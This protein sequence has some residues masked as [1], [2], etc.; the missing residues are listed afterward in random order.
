MS[1]RYPPSSFLKLPLEQKEKCMG[2]MDEQSTWIPWM[3]K[4]NGSH[5]R[6]KYMDPMVEAR[7]QIGNSRRIR[8]RRKESRALGRMGSRKNETHV[9]TIWPFIKGCLLMRPPVLPTRWRKEGLVIF[10]WIRTR[11][12]REIQRLGQSHTVGYLGTWT[13]LKSWV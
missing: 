2:P 4:V 12:M 10:V 6:A 8:G 3:S 9:H 1:E 11:W 13:G 7:L 5:G